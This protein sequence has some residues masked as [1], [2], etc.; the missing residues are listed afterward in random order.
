M[1]KWEITIEANDEASALVYLDGIK[2]SFTA[3]VMTGL[4]M[5]HCVMED[6]A[7]GEKTICT[8]IKKSWTIWDRK[9]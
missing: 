9:G 1:K 8:R 4:P 7:K 5:D 6:P 3:S 2:G